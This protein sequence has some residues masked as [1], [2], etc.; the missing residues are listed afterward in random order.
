M[1]D[2]QVTL[3]INL[4][5]GRVLSVTCDYTSAAQRIVEARRWPLY[6]DHT[7][8]GPAKDL[9]ALLADRLAAR[10]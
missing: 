7:L 8:D 9:A 3:T 4:H 5:D 10:A 2:D 1:D 6:K